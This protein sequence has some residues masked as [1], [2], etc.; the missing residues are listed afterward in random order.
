[1]NDLYVNGHKL[2]QPGQ[3]KRL[4]EKGNCQTILCVESNGKTK[5]AAGGHMERKPGEESEK[6]VALLPAVMPEHMGD[7]E[8][9]KTYGTKY[10]YYA[11]AMA[12]GISSVRMLV[13]LGRHGFMGSLGTGGMSLEEIETSIDELKR[14]LDGQCFLV[15]LLS[16]PNMPE[17][18]MKTIELYI[19]KNIRA[20]EASAFINITKALVYYRVSG[21]EQGKGGEIKIK[22]HLIA[23]ISR[24]EVAVKFMSPPPADLV[25]IL[26]SENK[27]TENQASLAKNIPMADDITVEA[28][29]GGHTDNR[30][31]VSLFPAIDTL[32]REINKK[33]RYQKKVRVGAGGGISTPA[34]AVAAFQ[35]G[36]AY[37]VTGSVNQSCIEAGTSDYVKNV[38]ADV[39]MQDVVMAPCADMFE[40]GAKVQVIKK[41]TMFPMNA[42][43]LYQYYNEYGSLE[44]IPPVQKASIEK[45]LF[46]NSLD[47]VWKQTEEFFMRTDPQ[48]A[49]IANKNEKYKMALVF[50]WYLGQSSKW[51]VSGDSDR[52]MDMQIWCGQSM[53]AF[54]NMVKG[55]KYEKPGNRKAAEIA[56]LIMQGAA[57]LIN[58]QYAL[59]L[60]ADVE[61]CREYPI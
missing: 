60:G 20:I 29:S 19:H 41:G 55:T 51:A 32:N 58:I 54:N 13:E 57:Y 9:I 2:L 16:S 18:E 47:E 35:M 37:I 21:I 53:G 34:S 3:L 36:A 10:A 12:N 31:L 27:I 24:E 40:M 50:R 38:L 4:L 42:Q 33:Y 43:K 49:A 59:L 45:R 11:G 23:K 14:S 25:N 48:Q 46:H 26:L 56:G 44:D 15:N 28:D 6:I 5:L 8:F 61:D 1:M 7:N 30:P 17:R 22:N 39:R 52:I